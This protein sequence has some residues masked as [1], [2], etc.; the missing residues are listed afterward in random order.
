[1]DIDDSSIDHIVYPKDLV[2]YAKKLCADGRRTSTDKGHACPPCSACAP[3]PVKSSASP[4]SVTPPALKGETGRR[5]FKAGDRL[6][7][8]AYSNWGEVIRYFEAV[9]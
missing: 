3:C 1:M 7:D 9:P 5:Y 8:T 2:A 6:P 4:V